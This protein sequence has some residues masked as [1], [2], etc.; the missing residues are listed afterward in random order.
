MS[1][2]KNALME[3]LECKVCDGLGYVS[4]ADGEDDFTNEECVC[5]PHGFDV[6]EWSN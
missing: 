6:S 4:I 5:N 1:A 2:I 3:I